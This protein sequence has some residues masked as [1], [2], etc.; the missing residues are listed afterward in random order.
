VSSYGG[1]FL[2]CFIH[3]IYK[4]YKLR[5]HIAK[6]LQARSKAVKAALLRFNAAGAALDEPREP[7][8]WEQV[9]EYAF[10]ADFDLLREGRTD[11]RAEPWA[12]P[13]GRVAMDTH[14]DLLRADEELIRLDIEIARFVTYMQDEELFLWWKEDTIRDSGNEELAH[15]VRQYRNERG[16]FTAVHLD[17]L[18]KLS[19]VPGFTASLTPGIS[20]S[21]ERA[22]P[23]EW[24]AAHDIPMPMAV[25]EQDG[26]D[27]GD[28]DEDALVELFANIILVSHDLRPRQRLVIA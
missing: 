1:F 12:L 24:L 2:Q 21:K 27:E 10:L 19:K 17:R 11:I 16:R 13:S 14:F 20:V 7:L 5:K 9:V 25:E 8:A 23:A 4:G 26:D 3:V 22:V 6:A 15:H 28:E 18:V